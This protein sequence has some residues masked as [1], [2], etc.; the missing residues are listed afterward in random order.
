MMA[1]KDMW[2][3]FPLRGLFPTRSPLLLRAGLHKSAAYQLSELRFH[4]RQSEG[5]FLVL[6]FSSF[7]I[8][9]HI[10]Q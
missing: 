10:K 2:H 8:I 4:T 3:V 6:V 9:P 7:S 5:R 1:L